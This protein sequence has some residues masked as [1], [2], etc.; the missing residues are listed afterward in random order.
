[1][2]IYI[3]RRQIISLLGA[4][5]AVRPLRASAQH[6][7]ARIAVLGSGR[8]QSSGIFLEALKRGL[9]DNG[10]IEGQGYWLDI[11]WAEGEYR[12]F[13]ALAAE[14]AK[15]NPGVIVATTIAAVRAAQRASST[16]PIVM[17]SINDP[18]GSGL[19]ASLARPSGNTTGM[20]NLTEDLTPKVLEILRAI[21]PTATAIATLFNPLNPSN[22]A[23]L[24]RIRAYAGTVDA[25]VQPAEFK[26]PGDL[27]RA[28]AAII[29]ERPHAL[30]I[31]NDFMILDMREEIMALAL[32][33]RLPAASSFPE[34][35]D[36]GAL[37][38]Y[39]PS[40]LA[41]WR[42]SAY[43]VKRILEG[44]KPSDLPVEQPTSIELSVN[45]KTAKALGIAIS[46]SFLA[47]VH[48]VVE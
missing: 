17:T 31:I 22:L 3:G 27:E 1:M 30:L 25:T 11:R 33:H 42:R 36:L 2:T 37:V 14:V 9:A 26:A 38:G 4:A 48:R 41:L 40:R 12:R 44:V 32:Q 7:P 19:V 18:V 5:A 39:G 34:F 20:A 24:D 47:R 16:I 45:L 21:I 29:R 15:Q 35:T 28:F 46:E 10:L 13:P 6:K 43:Y 8:A 23:I